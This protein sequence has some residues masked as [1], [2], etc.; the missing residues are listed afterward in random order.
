MDF[1]RPSPLG[2]ALPT[3]L[4]PAAASSETGVEIKQVSL[5]SKGQVYE[6]EESF[7]GRK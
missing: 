6:W 7:D 1:G 5:I 4:I 2:A 3:A